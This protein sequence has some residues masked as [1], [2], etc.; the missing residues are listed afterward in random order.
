MKGRIPNK[1]R[2]VFRS[3]NNANTNGG[4]SYAYANNDS[5][6]VNANYGCRLANNR[7]FVLKKFWRTAAGTCPRSGANGDAPQQQ[8]ELS[9][10][11]GKY[12]RRVEFGRGM[13]SCQPKKSDPE[14]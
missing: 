8:R 3:N 4:V 12:S 6:N 13:S 14:N 5:A 7:V 11:A 9:R 2:V 10:K 1:A